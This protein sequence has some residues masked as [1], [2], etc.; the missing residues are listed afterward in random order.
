MYDW[1]QEFPEVLVPRY[2]RKE[3]TERIDKNGKVWTPLDEDSV[4]EATKFLKKLKVE[5][6][7]V[8]FLYSF[9]D[10][11]HER[12][13][14]ELIKEVYPEVDVTISSDVLPVIGEYER[15]STAIINAFIAP[16]ITKYT[17]QVRIISGRRRFQRS[18]LIH[19]E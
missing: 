13:A 12:K 18:I 5:S 3:V 19:P 1:K 2:L 17:K 14:R 16:A 8:V 11:S 7:V 15:A 10:P 6:I 4:R 9:L